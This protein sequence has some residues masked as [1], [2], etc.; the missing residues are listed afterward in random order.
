MLQIIFSI[1]CFFNLLKL[2]HIN[3][4][5]II[6]EKFYIFI[7]YNK[8]FLFPDYKKQNIW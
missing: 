5:I 8:L 4:N 7:I 1:K 2:L 3:V 6:T